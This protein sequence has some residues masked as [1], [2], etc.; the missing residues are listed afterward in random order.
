MVF[1][2][3]EEMIMST[4]Q[5]GLEEAGSQA[6]ESQMAQ[7]A[8]A[9]D[10]SFPGVISILTAG[11][12]EHWRNEAMNSG[13]GWGAKYAAAIK[14][15]VT[16]DTGEVFLDESMTDKA[17][18]KLNMMYVKMV[19]SG[20]KSFSI[21]EGLMNSEKAK[22]SSTGIKYIVIPFPVRTP[23]KKGQGKM[24]SKFGGRE[25]TRDAYDLVK[26]GGKFSGKLK[27]GGDVTGLTRY[28]TRQHNVQYGSFICV[29]QNSKGWIHPGVPASPVF[30]SVL[31][32]AN[33]RAQEVISS[34]IKGVVREFTQ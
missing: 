28:V 24:T 25:M 17:S 30:P 22:V 3:D 7:I 26:S 9:I 8:N 23:P 4:I 1:N 16:G 2:F 34:F 29:T 20:M 11:I 31:S 13:T 21:K 15:K 32:E 14:S 12:E 27:S 5:S 19:E 18:G 33:K 6:S 10:E